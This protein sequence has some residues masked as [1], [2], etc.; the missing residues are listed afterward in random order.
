MP[1]CVSCAPLRRRLFRKKTCPRWVITTTY[2]CTSELTNVS[3]NISNNLSEAHKIGWCCGMHHTHQRVRR[4]DSKRLFG[5]PVLQTIGTNAAGR[6]FAIQQRAMA[7]PA[8]NAAAK[9][10][11]LVILRLILAISGPARLPPGTE[12]MVRI[13]DQ[14]STTR[15]A[16]Q[17]R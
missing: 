16:C 9:F 12:A 6:S 10:D 1:R 15:R 13:P 14:R 7:S 3:W 5:T 17:G 4:S 11:C 8:G 2:I